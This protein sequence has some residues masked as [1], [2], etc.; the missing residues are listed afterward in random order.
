M[1]L[2]ARDLTTKNQVR[3]FGVSLE[4]DLSF[5]SHVKTKTKELDALFPIKT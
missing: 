4:S 1:H 5:S 2:D 3:N